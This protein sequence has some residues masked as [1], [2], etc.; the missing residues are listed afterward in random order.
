[1]D[2]RATTWAVCAALALTACGS[3]P[4]G[5][6][7]EQSVPD[8]AWCDRISTD[9]LAE[10]IGLPVTAKEPVALDDTI[11][12][13]VES[14]AVHLGWQSRPADLTVREF[15]ETYNTGPRALE[16]TRVN[17]TIDAVMATVAGEDP[18][19]AAALYLQ[20]GDELLVVTAS[21]ARAV[22]ASEPPLPA[23]APDLL[24]HLVAQ[25]LV[26]SSTDDSTPDET[27]ETGVDPGSGAPSREAAADPVVPL[28]EF[29]RDVRAALAA[30][31]T[32]HA[33]TTV[34]E[35]TTRGDYDYRRQPV[36]YRRTTN[37]DGQESQEIAL[38][39]H[40]YSES[41]AGFWSRRPRTELTDG[42]ADPI[43]EIER[44]LSKA[45]EVRDLG[46]TVVEGVALHRYAVAVGTAPG[47]DPDLTDD[48]P[49]AELVADLWLDDGHRI[50]RMSGA[51]GND[52]NVAMAALAGDT[53]HD[54][55]TFSGFDAPLTIERPKH[56]GPQLQ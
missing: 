37:R 26:L 54:L 5:S 23:K 51:I 25:H 34:G 32:V 55:T 44:L 2:T 33:E 6:A 52:W 49:L 24:V 36:A 21:L 47:P 30:L 45:E 40:F 17:D 10:L 43:S 9:E 19:T 27:G 46:P 42:P 29:R 35:T 48:E 41:G 15:A 7:A 13:N 53:P 38:G 3:D 18:T 8:A 14:E 39:K 50:H 22:G 1:M 12:C 20:V 56:V 4:G 31:T 28:T 11:T 16:N